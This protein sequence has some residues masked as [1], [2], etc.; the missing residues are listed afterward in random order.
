M[1]SL[2]GKLAVLNCFLS[3]SAKKSLPFF[4]TL[5]DITKDNKNNYRWIEDAEKAFQELK[6]MILN[7]SSLT[8]QLPKETLCVYL[9]AS[10]EVVIAVLL[11][12]RKGKQCRVHYVSRTLHDVERN[13]AP[14]EKVDLALLHVSRRLKR[15]LEAHPIKVITDQPI[16]DALVPWHA[17]YTMDQ[18]TDSK[19]EWVLY[20]DKASTI[21]GSGAGLVLISPTKIEYT[22]VMRLNFTSINNQAEYEAL[23]AGQRIAKKMK[24]ALNH[25]TKEILVEV[26]ETPSIDKQE[27]NAV[28]EEE[29][30]K[31]MTLIIKCL[32]EGKWL[33]DLNEARALRMKIN[34]Y[35]VEEGVMLKRS[36]LIP[37]L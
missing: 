31:Q 20:T 23:L 4:E 17:P 10:K 18:Q 12:K 2:L 11:A 9:A 35:V 13:Y 14:L 27:I 7:M 6:K 26:L 1:Q 34:E 29:E 16:N 36:Y 21:K 3:R 15:Y 37:M 25:I 32:E 33:E 22:Y 19:E 24:V 28:V 5:K 8:T 30:E